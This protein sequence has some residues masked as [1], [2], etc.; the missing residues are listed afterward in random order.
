MDRGSIAEH[1][2]ILG[3][4]KGKNVLVHVMQNKISFKLVAIDLLQKR[5]NKS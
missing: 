4:W 2:F 5:E 1:V 3:M